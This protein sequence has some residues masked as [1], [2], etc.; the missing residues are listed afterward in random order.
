MAKRPAKAKVGRPSVL[1]PA[2][3]EKI[4]EA[5][6]AGLF[7]Q[8]AADW[9]GIGQRTLFT[10]LQQGK[11]K[12]SSPQG[13]FRQAVL[14]AEKAAEMRCSALIQQAAGKDW[15]A[16]AWFLERKFHSRW[17]R[18]Q[19]LQHTGA[20]GGPLVVNVISLAE[21]DDA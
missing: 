13:A 3:Q 4:L 10:W 19:T 21:A 17:G 18:Q 1:T 6:K 2:L 14:K 8:Q 7:R 15:K 12:P 5:I 9:A 11:A 16:A 20:Q